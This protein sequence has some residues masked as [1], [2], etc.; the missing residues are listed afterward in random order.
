M[1]RLLGPILLVVLILGVGAAIFLSASEQIALRRVITVRGLIGSEKE[2]FFQNPRVV[3]ELRKGGIEVQ[4]EKAGSRTIA[5]HEDLA[6]YDFA[7]PAGIPSAE[8][9]RQSQ[10]S[11]KTYDVFYTPM[12]IASWKSIAQILEANGAAEDQSGYYTL[13]MEAYLR[14]V[15][16]GARW[17]ALNESDAYPVN[18]NILIASTDVR[19]SN[20][21]AMYLSLAS[22]VANGNNIV[23]DDAQMQK[24]LP[25]MEALFLKQGYTEYSSEAPFEDYLVMGPGKSPM[26]MIYEG[27]FIYQS[28]QPNGI[29]SD[30]ALMYPEPTI[31]SKHIL[32]AFSEGGQRLGELLMNDPELQK[33]AIEHGFRNNNVEYFKQFKQSHGLALPD[34]LV[35]VIDPPSY[36]MLERM[37]QQIEKQYQ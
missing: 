5:V 24:I 35:D 12:A 30:M 9:I 26:V 20:S 36:E 21:A 13:D 2:E 19:K 28:T 22:Y 33:L 3:E 16:E 34:N 8:K 1:K 11:A 31:Y 25:L 29:S 18:K 4:V 14:Y 32:V 6:T 37:I 23:Q 7:F 27:Q 10:P 15:E 17:R